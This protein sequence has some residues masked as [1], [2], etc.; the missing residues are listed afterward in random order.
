MHR[1]LTIA[2]AAIAVSVGVAGQARGATSTV[3]LH[4][5]ADTTRF[6]SDSSSG[7]AIPG[8]SC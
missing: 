7:I 5:A 2:F 6:L 1:K 3:R 4:T 8:G